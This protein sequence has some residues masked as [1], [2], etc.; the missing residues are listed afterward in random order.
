MPDYQYDV[1][2][3]YR[4][5]PLTSDWIARVVERLNFWLTEELGGQPARIFFDRE[6]I[7][8][9]DRWPDTIREALKTSKCMV[10]L[11]S[12]SYFQSHWCVSEWR[13][14]LARER[15]FAATEPRRL[16]API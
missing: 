16:I 6:G 14:F 12:P 3:S 13:S 4:N 7:R 2:F 10:G 15:L 11:W 1:F 8:V 9:G 5:H